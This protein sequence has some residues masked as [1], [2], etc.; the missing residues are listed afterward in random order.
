MAPQE[1]LSKIAK[2]GFAIIDEFYS[3]SRRQESQICEYPVQKSYPIWRSFATPKTIDSNQA[4][5]RYGGIESMVA[6][7]QSRKMTSRANTFA[8][9]ILCSALAVCNA[10]N[11][12][13]A[14]H[15]NLAGVVELVKTFNVLNYGAKP[16]SQQE[17]TQAF[18]KAWQEA[19]GFIGN[20]RV[21]VVIPPG[22]Y[23]LSELIFQGPCKSPT[24]ITILLQGTLQAVSDI[25]A[26]PNQAWISFDEINGLILT[27]GGT[28]DGQGQA[29]WEYNDCKT[30]P[31]CT[32]LPAAIHMSKVQNAK[33]KSINMINSMGFHMHITQSYLVRLHSLHITSPGDSP[34]TD[35]IHISKSN[36]IKISRNVIKTGDDCISIGQ[37]S[38]NVTINQ[39]TCGPGHGI[40]VGSLGKVPNEMDV[41]GLIVKNSTL[42]G[43]TNGIRIKTYPASGPSRASGMLFKDIIMDNVKNPII[44]NQ[45]YGSD[46]T[47]P[48]QVRISDVVYQNIRGTT[49]SPLAV[50]LNCS[51]L[52]PCQNVHFQNIN[53]QHIAN[54]K[55]T[56][57]CANAKVGYF[58]VQNPPPC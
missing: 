7:Q 24:P 25:S 19:C 27:G 55:L 11:G 40:S 47:Q 37:G 43:T 20:G 42:I 13:Q 46:S 36:T 14:G 23:K 53:L 1:N 9:L 58:G 34:N 45:N 3:R 56:S 29:L 31:D 22:I 28:I 26:Y 21:R 15:R 6:T 8:V 4:A 48:S 32:H 54:Q 41:R 39:I 30:N 5:K 50:S 33:I 16:G 51:S 38:T 57:T 52:V 35:G 44:I 18:S 12:Q 49:I 2:E 10:A 17:S